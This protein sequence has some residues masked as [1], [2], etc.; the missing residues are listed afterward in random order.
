MS[1]WTLLLSFPKTLYY[2]LR[3]FPLSV[4]IRIPI[5]F[6]KNVR[7]KGMHRGC[8]IVENEK[9]AIANIGFFEGIGGDSSSHTVLDFRNSG[10][11]VL[12]GKCCIAKGSYVLADHSKIC[13]GEHFHGGANLKVISRSSVIIGSDCLTAWDCTIMD[14]DGHDILENERVLN[15]PRP[16]VIGEHVWMGVGCSILK[17]AVVPDN[18]VLGSNTVV[19]KT[20][21]DSNAAYITK[22]GETIAVR[23]NVT[24]KQ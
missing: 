23:H 18:T 20:L 6:H 16:I 13:I 17:G 14:S 10:E 7:I 19:T 1:I 9:T 15:A 22:N 4:A 24:W 5:V 3:L 12:K 2:N 8:I 11:L 21:P